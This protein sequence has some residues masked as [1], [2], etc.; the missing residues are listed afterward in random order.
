MGKVKGQ[1]CMD[2]TYIIIISSDPPSHVMVLP[3]NSMKERKEIIKKGTKQNK[4]N[5]PKLY[6]WEQTVIS[7]RNYFYLL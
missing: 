1:N 3:L 5:K 2:S 4:T 6:T 7:N